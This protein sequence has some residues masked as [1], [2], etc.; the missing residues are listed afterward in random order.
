MMAALRADMPMLPQFSGAETGLRRG[1]PN[2]G[3]TGGTMRILTAEPITAEAF[4]PFGVLLERPG[5]FGRRYFDEGL[6]NR[7]RDVSRS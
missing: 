6:C 5:G 1:P 4:A 2:L 3:R 7:D